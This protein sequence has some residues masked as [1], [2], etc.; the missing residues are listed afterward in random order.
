MAFTKEQVEEAVNSKTNATIG[1][2]AGIVQFRDS[3]IYEPV[4]DYLTGKNPSL[5]PMQLDHHAYPVVQLLNLLKNIEQPSVNDQLV[6]QVI[7]HP[8]DGK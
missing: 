1:F 8:D 4:M 3:T 5:P 2:H 7:R 6:L